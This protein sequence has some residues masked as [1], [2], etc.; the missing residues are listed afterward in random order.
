MSSDNFPVNRDT[1]ACAGVRA[2]RD[3]VAAMIDEIFTPDSSRFWEMSQWREG[4]PAVS[5]DKQF[6]RD[7]VETLGW[8]K[9][10][11]GPALPD[12]VVR[13]TTKRYI[14]AAKRICGIEI[15]GVTAE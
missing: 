13:G 12:E 10:D 1:P 7:Y 2:R 3:L 4:E 9:T 8:D 11:P 5:F 6:V 14:E 15:E